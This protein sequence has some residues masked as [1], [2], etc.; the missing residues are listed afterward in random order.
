[1]TRLPRD[2]RPLSPGFYVDGAGTVHVVVSEI[3]DLFQLE[4]TEANREAIARMLEYHGRALLP[5]AEF[6]RED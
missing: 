5:H 1:M 4:D 6:T 3:L 2:W